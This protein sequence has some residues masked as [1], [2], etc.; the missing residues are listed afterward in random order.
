MRPKFSDST[1]LVL[2]GGAIGLSASLLHALHGAP[3]IW[4]GKLNPARQSMLAAQGDFRIFDLL[5]TDGLPAGDADLVVDGLGSE[6]TQAHA[7]RS[8]RPAGVIAHIGLGSASSGLDVR[9]LTLQEI[10]FFGK[11][12]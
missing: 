4:I 11:Y 2:G 3:E 10:T 5:A 9:R 1:C 7:S 6:T 12:T 8:L